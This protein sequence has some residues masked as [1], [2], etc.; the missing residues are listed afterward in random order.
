MAPNKRSICRR[1]LAPI[2]FSRVPPLP[3][4]IA[5]W[6]SRS[7][8]I[9]APMRS[10]LPS[11]VKRSISTVVAYGSSS[12]SWRISCSRTSSPA[13]K[14]WLRSVISSSP[15][16]GGA[17]GSSFSTSRT[18]ASRPLRFCAEIGCT[19]AKSRPS[20]TCCRNGSSAPFSFRRSI[21]LTT[22]TTG[23]P[24]SRS[25]LKARLSSSSQRPASITSRPASTPSSEPRAARFITRF[26]ARFCT[27]CRPGVSTS[28][29]CPSG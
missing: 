26:I 21:L 8:Q 5:F 25:T 28:T 15:N 17:S 11:S 29:S 4:T 2:S 18:S 3:I 16:I 23:M 14:R 9:T 24:A 1:D 12:P 19:A 27:L 22:S 6:P 10:R 13:R 7:T 20:V